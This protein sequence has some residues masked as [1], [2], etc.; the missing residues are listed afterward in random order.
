MKNLISFLACVIIACVF[1][2]YRQ[3][4]I[5]TAK[6]SPT[7]FTTWDAFG[8]YMYLPSA[9][10]YDDFTELEWVQEMD[11]KYDLVGGDMYQSNKYTNGN[12]VNK[13]LGGVSLMQAPLF[14]VGHIVALNTDYPADGFSLP[15][16]LSLGYGVLLYC[17]LAL[18]ML[19]KILLRYFDD[20]AVAVSLILMFLATN[21]VQYIPIEAGQSH[22]YIFPLYVLVLYTT[23]KWHE[24]PKSIWAGLTGLIIGLATICRPTEAIMFLI[25]L[26]WATHTKDEKSRKWALVKENRSHII[27]AVLFGVIGIIPQLIYWKMTSGELIYNVG[28]SWRFLTP[29]FRVLV[30]WEIGWFIYTPITIFFIIGLFKIKKFPFKRSVIVFCLLNMWIVISWADWRY[31]ATYSTRALVQSFPIFAL[32]FTAIIE[33]INFTKWKYPFYALGLYLIFVNLFQIEQYNDTIL[34]YRDMNRLYYSRIYLN[35]DV[36]SL[37]MSLLDTDEVLD[38]HSSHT[39]GVL[40]TSNELINVSMENRLLWNEKAV[41]VAKDHWLR[42][43]AEI[44]ADYGFTSSHLHCKIISGK[45]IKERK[46]RLFNAIS[47]PGDFNDYAFYVRV[48]DNMTKVDLEVFIGTLDNFVGQLRKIKVTHLSTKL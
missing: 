31:G 2:Q 39:E 26:L 1:V 10:I 47:K 19:R 14:M 34:H 9:F 33:R 15:Y 30:G 43:D 17:M 45:V 38:D 44:K 4:T 25:P 46:V 40:H 48:P 24:R 20:M 35:N 23:I 27:Y 3:S 7:V 8:Y 22:P 37:D 18:F 5:S 29:F 16:Q 12:Y 41:T 32:P 13:Y 28:S 6:E 21:L 11:E 42:V 36:N